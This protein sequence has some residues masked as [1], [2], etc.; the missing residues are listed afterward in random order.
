MWFGRIFS[1]PFCKIYEAWLDFKIALLWLFHAPDEEGPKFTVFLGPKF[2]TS[3][4]MIF[5]PFSLAVFIRLTTHELICWQM[6]RAWLKFRFLGP[7]V[8]HSS[9]YEIASAWKIWLN[10]NANAF[11]KRELFSATDSSFIAV[12]RIFINP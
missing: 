9:D 8:Y 5:A 10:I 3:F 7:F 1:N 4:L 12:L 6:W 11:S 2:A